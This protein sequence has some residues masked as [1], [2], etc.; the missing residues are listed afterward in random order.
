M[1]IQIKT[2]WNIHYQRVQKCLA[3]LHNLEP[4]PLSEFKEKYRWKVK[5]KNKSNLCTIQQFIYVL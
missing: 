1:Q 3:R 2:F 5:K 4:A